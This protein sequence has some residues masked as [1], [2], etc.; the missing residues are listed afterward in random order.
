MKLSALALP[1]L[2][3]ASGCGAPIATLVARA[4]FDFSCPERDLRV[5]RLSDQTFGVTGCNRRAVYINICD[6]TGWGPM[7]CRWVMNSPD[8]SA[9]PGGPANMPYPPPAPPGFPATMAP[10]PR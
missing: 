7:N 9:V 1:F 10:A 3:L 6:V 2:V 8:T 5:T 4:Q